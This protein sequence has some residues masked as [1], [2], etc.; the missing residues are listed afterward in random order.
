MTSP[1]HKS[2]SGYSMVPLINRSTTY[3]ED[4]LM[5]DKHMSRTSTHVLQDIP[6][7]LEVTSGSEKCEESADNAGYCETFKQVNKGNEVHFDDE[8]N[9]V[10]ADEKDYEHH[11][12]DE[13][14]QLSANKSLSLKTF[15][16]IDYQVLYRKGV[17]V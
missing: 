1:T 17:L 9:K 5:S 4:S 6:E 14:L 16:I 2:L 13:H 3:M 15:Q 12:D 11:D 7:V 8:C 10:D